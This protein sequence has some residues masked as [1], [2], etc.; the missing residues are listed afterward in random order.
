VDA[1]NVRPVRSRVLRRDPAGLRLRAAVRY[2]L[3][4]PTNR[5]LIAASS[6]GYFFFAGMR[7]FGVVFVRGH[8]GLGQSAAIA[9]LFVAGL[10]SLAG[11][12]TSGRLADRLVSRGTPTARVLVGAICYFGA[13]AVLLP[14]LLVGS[15]ALALPLLA[16]A[17]AG[18][19]APN[20][21]LD[22]ARLDIIPSGLWGRAEGVRTLVRQSAQAVAPLV[23]GFVADAL[24]ATGGALGV[25][26]AI[27]STSARAL[28]IT[29]L[30]MLI[31]LAAN[32]GLLL[33]ARRTYAA[34][35]ATAVESESASRR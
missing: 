13:A 29:F 8:F 1:R 18:L 35:M 7:T 15:V 3:R 21:P 19:A 11:V 4:I 30:V 10:G 25:R 22:A 6:V 17:A 24:G 14:A 33:L 9:V 2:V 16:V 32:G 27:S 26:S 28:D 12:L 31:P 34:D 5:W 23:F 20:P